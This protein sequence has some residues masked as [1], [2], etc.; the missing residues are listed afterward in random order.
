MVAAA[1][2]KKNE[3]W[4]LLLL[5]GLLGLSGVAYLI[6]SRNPSSGSSSSNVTINNNPPQKFGC[7]CGGG[8]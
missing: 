8:S 7:G 6:K 2:G 4:L 1:S 5:A 3:N